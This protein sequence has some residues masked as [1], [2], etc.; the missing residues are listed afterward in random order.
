MRRHCRLVVRPGL[1]RFSITKQPARG[2]TRL[3]LLAN[4]VWEVRDDEDGGG[5]GEDGQ[6][7]EEGGAGRT[8][9]ACRQDG[10]SQQKVSLCEMRIPAAGSC[11]GL[12]FHHASVFFMG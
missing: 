8:R 7:E 10:H 4:Q 5:W 9:Q 6:D 2:A 1:S 12:A 11:A 3:L